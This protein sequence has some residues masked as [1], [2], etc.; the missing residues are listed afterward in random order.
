MTVTGTSPSRA[1][2]R[3]GRRPAIGGGD[4]EGPGGSDAGGLCPGNTALHRVV[5]SPGQ[6]LAR[7]RHGRIDNLVQKCRSRWPLLEATVDTQGLT[8]PIPQGYTIGI[9]ASTVMPA[10]QSRGFNLLFKTL[11]V[12]GA[13]YYN[14]SYAGA[15]QLSAYP[16]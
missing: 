15:T 1:N 10:G 12:H 7:R 8:G 11:Q 9:P 6:W 4:D 16:T 2:R 3:G 5:R 14:V 13:L